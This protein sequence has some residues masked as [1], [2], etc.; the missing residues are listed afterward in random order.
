MARKPPSKP[1]KPSSSRTA[2]KPGTD[3]E[4]IIRAFMNLLAEKPIENIGLAEIARSAGVSL[5]QLRGEFDSP[6]SIFAA[7]VKEI[8]R[9]VLEGGSG[10]MAEEPPR[11]RLFEILMRRLEALAPYKPAV[12]SLMR[13]ATCNPGLA[14]ALNRLTVISLQWMLTAADIGASGPKGVVR[15]QGLALL[16]MQVLRVWIDDDDPGLAKTMSA[17]DRALTRGQSWSR[18]FDDLCA[19]I[20][21]RC[22]PRQRRGR[23]NDARDEPAAA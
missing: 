23:R 15:A 9:Q 5:S 2:P 8:D 3:R 21:A 6:L 18:L 11:D 7:Q 20:P 1:A 17:L 14:L 16:F 22:P 13:S 12:R 19:L 4:R 10:D